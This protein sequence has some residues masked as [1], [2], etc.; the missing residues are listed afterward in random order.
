MPE[1]DATRDELFNSIEEIKG[2]TFEDRPPLI[3]IF[4]NKDFKHLL[5]KIDSILPELISD[6][7]PITEI[8]NINYGAALFI[9]RKM[10]PWFDEKRK[11]Q[12]KKGSQIFPWKQKLQKRLDKFRGEL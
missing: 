9:Q 1:E 8:N 2:M 11:A 12:K 7:V 5:S 3:K 4:E 10:A 6:D